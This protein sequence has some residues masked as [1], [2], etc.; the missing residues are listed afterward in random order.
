MRVTNPVMLLQMGMEL[1]TTPTPWWRTGG[2]RDGLSEV[3]R[4]GDVPKP[5]ETSGG[6]TIV[7]G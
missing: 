5:P 7:H 2:G 3:L 4:G 6:Y 1:A